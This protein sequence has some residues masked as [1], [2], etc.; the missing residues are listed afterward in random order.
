MNIKQIT[1]SVHPD[2]PNL[3]HVQIETSNGIVGTGETYYFGSTVAHFI[4]DY[5][6]P[7]II[8]KSAVEIEHINRLLTTYVGYNG[9]G[10]E[11]RAR[12]AIDI[13]LWDIRAQAEGLPLYK[14]LG[15]NA[16]KPLKIYNTCAGTSYMRKSNQSSNSWGLDS[17]EKEY[18]DLARFMVDAGGL[19]KELLAEGISA[20]KIWPFDLFAECTQGLTISNEDLNLA[21]QPIRSIREAVGSQMDIMV[22]MHSLW[23]VE[24][25]KKI[26]TALKEFNVFWVEDPLIPDLL[27]EYSELRDKGMPKIAHGETVASK[28]RINRL[29]TENLIDFLTLD[30]G[31]CGGF[32]Q[33]ILYSALAKKNGVQIA[34]HDCT[35]PIG[36]IAGAHLSTAWDGEVIQETVRAALRTWYPLIV[37]DLPKIDHGFLTLSGSPGLGT[38]LRSEYLSDSRNNLQSY[39][40]LK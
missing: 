26:L 5:V 4:H 31:W 39:S 20:M 12:S 37:N 40:E 7:T 24:P 33:G 22:E 14:L 9:S 19:G 8:G 29:L 10:V 35:G 34:P 13:A 3:M 15:G 30:L 11:T 27:D 25:A 23:H 6:A 21:L 17:K 16:A 2:F 18:Q 36:L 38:S 28:F 1:T 32:S